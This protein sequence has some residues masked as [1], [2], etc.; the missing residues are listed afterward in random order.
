[1]EPKEISPDRAAVE[2]VRQALHTGQLEELF[3]NLWK[4]SPWWRDPALWVVMS[5][6]GAR[7]IGS[8]GEVTWATVEVDGE[9]VANPITRD[10]LENWLATPRPARALQ[11][12][13]FLI[14][15]WGDFA[16]LD[17]LVE[18]TARHNPVHLGTV[19]NE[20]AGELDNSAAAWGW[21]QRHGNLL[22]AHHSGTSAPPYLHALTLDQL[23]HYT[24]KCA[25]N[26]RVILQDELYQL[27]RAAPQAPAA[28]TRV[29]TRA[30]T[31]CLEDAFESRFLVAKLMPGIRVLGVPEL[32][33]LLDTACE[34]D[35]LFAAIA[36]LICDRDDV[37]AEVFAG[38]LNHASR[39]PDAVRCLAMLGTGGRGLLA[40][41]I[42][43]IEH[44]QVV[45]MATAVSQLPSV[46]VLHR[47]R[48][49]SCV[50][51]DRTQFRLAQEPLSPNTDPR[52]QAISLAAIKA[53]V[54]HSKPARTEASP[55]HW[56]DALQVIAWSSD[57]AWGL[58]QCREH[59][60]L[61][62]GNERAALVAAVNRFDWSRSDPS[63]M[64]F[65][66]GA[67]APQDVLL[68]AMTLAVKHAS[69]L[70]YDRQVRD[71]FNHWKPSRWQQ[72][73]VLSQSLW[74]R[75]SNQSPG[76]RRFE[77]ERWPTLE[78]VHA[79]LP[80]EHPW[81]SAAS[82]TNFRLRLQ[83][84]GA[85]SVRLS[86]RNRV[87]FEVDVERETWS[88]QGL[89]GPASGPTSLL[90]LHGGTV[91]LDVEAN[92]IEIRIGVGEAVVTSDYRF[93]EHGQE[94]GSVVA[95]A[96]GQ[97]PRLESLVLTEINSPKDFNDVVHLVLGGRGAQNVAGAGT[98]WAAHALAVA[99]SLGDQ[100]L[101][102]T[103]R[104]LLQTMGPVADPWRQVLG[105]DEK[106]PQPYKTRSFEYCVSLFDATKSDEQV[107]RG[108]MDGMQ[109]VAF[110][111]HVNHDEHDDDEHD[112]DEHD[113]D[114]YEY[115]TRSALSEP[116]LYLLDPD[117]SS[118]D[119]LT[120]P[121]AIQEQEFSAITTWGASGDGYWACEPGKWLL[122]STTEL[123]QEQDEDYAEMELIL[124][125]WRVEEGIACAV[126]AGNH[127]VLAS[128][129]GLPGWPHPR[130]WKP[131]R[132]CIGE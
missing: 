95:H 81:E 8:D 18:A 2:A 40:K 53:L 124:A 105:L 45:E 92:G 116:T 54:G 39:G 94:Q 97:N 107:R 33:Q 63:I 51:I 125:A 35:T 127:D 48:R 62:R 60:L 78:A 110:G 7:H 128:I 73:L 87:S 46:R 115:R 131:T 117:Q 17:T 91:Q 30:I 64:Y 58:K 126:W 21:V 34:N 85:S 28:Y 11:W 109:A 98:D 19:V 12:M 93:L 10:I 79:P 118:E 26:E 122:V 66:L 88:Q 104:N 42:R 13:A 129:V 43:E 3:D 1:M 111:L 112:D 59:N 89:E 72:W 113:D 27:G 24:E 121:D 74:I 14:G 119:L 86:L 36:G 56:A 99:A 16:W 55:H 61:G 29:A 84:S 4:R 123:V 44:G 96:K 114:E 76:D 22:I 70:D 6:D 32:R 65:L 57:L 49:S 67:N 101:R 15:R 82:H 25:E 69:T 132:V 83:V 31:H 120:D 102:E 23:V 77:L 80:L 5:V 68:H 75:K 103:T 47:P 52:H 108:E 38:F 37:G 106:T 20:L 9:R 50:D 71:V 130:A 100:E 90:D 41:K